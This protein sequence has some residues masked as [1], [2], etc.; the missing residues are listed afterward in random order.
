M[1]RKMLSY[2]TL[3]IQYAVKLNNIIF[4][5]CLYM[6]TM[7]EMSSSRVNLLKLIVR[8]RRAVRQ[9]ISFILLRLLPWRLSTWRFNTLIIVYCECMKRLHNQAVMRTAR[10]LTVIWLRTLA[11]ATLSR[12]LPSKL[13]NLGCGFSTGSM[14]RTSLSIMTL[15]EEV[16]SLS[17]WCTDTAC[18]SWP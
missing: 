8:C 1:V 12:I 5:H 6:C 2:N 3:L 7:W 4:Y 17:V 18:C 10:I 15:L 16:S 13:N 11:L 9:E 14:L